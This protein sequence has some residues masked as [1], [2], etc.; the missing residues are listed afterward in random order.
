VGGWTPLFEIGDHVDL[1]DLLLDNGADIKHKTHEGSNVL[2]LATQRGHSMVCKKL[3]RA[4]AGLDGRTSI[5]Y[6]P[7]HLAA[8][9]SRTQ[10]LTAILRAA[11]DMKVSL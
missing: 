1:V 7:I 9:Y 2:H 5:N 3:M 6:S 8:L 11:E 10:S 4:G